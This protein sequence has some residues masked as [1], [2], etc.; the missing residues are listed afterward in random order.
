MTRP[1]GGP[2][3]DRIAIVTGGSRGVGRAVVRRLTRRGFAVVVNYL[4]D[5]RAAD[6]TVDLVLAD[7]GEAMA[8]RGDVADELDMERL[9]AET[10]EAFGGVD[11][12][13][14]S[15][16][17]RLAA[18][19]LTEMDLETFD[20]LARINTRAAFVVCREA[21]RRL[22]PGGAIVSVSTSVYGSS[23]I[24]YGAS[25]ATSAATDVLTRALARELRSSNI[26]VNAVV[27]EPGRP[28]LPGRVADVV[29]YLLSDRGHDL[30]G[31]VIRLDGPAEFS[32]AGWRPL[33]CGSDQ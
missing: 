21:A 19:P 17:S 25:A 13:T 9:F 7:G 24:G 30:N 28:C 8:V 20:E 1:P 29:A 15:V 32:A 6:S 14:H 26:T 11:V 18:E 5:Q 27:L 3:A 12:V 31:E 4:H 33:E 22:R 23:L 2:P 10:T 16:G